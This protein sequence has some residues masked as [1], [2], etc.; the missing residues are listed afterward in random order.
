MTRKS[1][2]DGQ[3]FTLPDGR[4]LGYLIVGEG[5]PVFHFHGYPSSRLEVLNFK[6]V[7]HAYNLKFIGV[8]RPGFGLSSF[9]PKMSVCDFTTDFSFL[10]DHLG[11]DKFSLIGYSTGGPYAITSATLLPER[12][13]RVL[14]ISGYS[15]PID[16]SDMSTDIKRSHITSFIAT[17]VHKRIRDIFLEIAEDPEAF[18]ESKAGKEMLTNLP[19]YDAKFWTTSS[20]NRYIFFRS[21]VEA[22]KQKNDSIKMHIQELKNMKK[23]WEVDLSKM[24]KDLI[25]IWHGSS[26]TIIPIS[27]AYKN[28]KALPGSHLD[29]FENAGH[30][31]IYK[32]P[33]KLGEILG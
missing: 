12:V 19:G 13:V 25:Y 24:P 28:A 5:K 23:G 10:A 33:E 14:I 15:L 32:N 17:S 11:I 9:A 20:E 21:I 3:T 26:D 31:L 2:V 29:I 27:N 22:Y 8:D 6:G 30:M 7:S 4:K 1:N 18:I 16:T